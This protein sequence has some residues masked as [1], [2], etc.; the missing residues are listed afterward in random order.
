MN[1][2]NTEDA[3]LDSIVTIYYKIESKTPS[4]TLDGWSLSE[5]RE[6]LS[7]FLSSK[8]YICLCGEVNEKIALF[9]FCRVAST[10]LATMEI[11]CKN[12]DLTPSDHAELEPRATACNPVFAELLHELKR[13]GVQTINTLINKKHHNFRLQTKLLEV[14]GFTKTTEFSEY[15]MDVEDAILDYNQ[16]L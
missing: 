2:R 16:F 15:E 10:H 7:D 1:V 12:P 13:R 6:Q 3:D 5:V 9:V 4:S 11:F 8:S 14:G